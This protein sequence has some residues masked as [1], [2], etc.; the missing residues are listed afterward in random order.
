MLRL[1][2]EQL[3]PAA[4]PQ[5]HRR[6]AH[7]FGANGQPLDAIGHAVAAEAWD[8]AAELV[9]RHWLPLIA[10]GKA[11]SVRAYVER[12][13]AH[14]VHADAE[15]ALAMAGL[16]FEDGDEAGAEALFA[17][18]E[19]LGAS[20]PESRRLRFGAAATSVS[21]YRARLR[22]DVE[23]ALEAARVALAKPWSEVVGPRAA[24]SDADEPRNGR[25]R[26]G[27]LRLGRRTPPAGRRPGEGGGGE[28]L[29]LLAEV[30]GAAVDMRE[31]RRERAEARAGAAAELVERRGWTQT[32]AAAQA[33]LS[34]ARPSDVGGRPCRRRDPG[35]PRV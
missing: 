9:G 15:L 32:A 21:L 30:Y 18:A 24:R 19:P 10:R 5:L 13:P 2:S 14:V 29:L 28:Y 17:A 3:I 12:I 7:W 11:S 20:L 27:R 25:V 35:G 33:Y 31:G 34:L 22:G 6:A 16:L 1:E 4:L 26:G 8:L 23:E